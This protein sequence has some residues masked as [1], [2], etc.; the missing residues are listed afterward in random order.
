MHDRIDI[1]PDVSSLKEKENA[2]FIIQ[3]VVSENIKNIW[4]KK[5]ISD[6]GGLFSAELS[7]TSVALITVVYEIFNKMRRV[8]FVICVVLIHFFFR[9]FYKVRNLQNF[10]FFIEQLSADKKSSQVFLFLFPLDNFQNVKIIGWFFRNEFCFE[11]LPLKN[12]RLLPMSRKRY[13]ISCFFN[14]L[15]WNK[16]I[17][18]WTK[19][20]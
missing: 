19:S 18:W 14:R 15:L 16:Y 17:L 9:H 10:G 12:M 7:R 2:S 13:M 5:T 6:C 11:I 4:T 1:L 8:N 3:S 20:L